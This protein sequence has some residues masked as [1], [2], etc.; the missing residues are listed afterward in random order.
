MAGESWNEAFERFG[1]WWRVADVDVHASGHLTFS[2]ENGLSLRTLGGAWLGGD[3]GDGRSVTHHGR[4]DD[5][6]WTLTGCWTRS[7]SSSGEV[8][9]VECAFAGVGMNDEELGQLDEIHVEFDG[10]GGQTDLPA[11]GHLDV[12]LD[13]HL[14]AERGRLWTPPGRPDRHLGDTRL[15]PRSLAFWVLLRDIASDV[16]VLRRSMSARKFDGG[17]GRVVDRGDLCVTMSAG[18]RDCCRG[19]T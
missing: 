1:T 6:L 5:E 18:A 4:V 17:I 9:H 10:V 8:F 19:W 2:P 16:S 12:P 3:L 15:M 7:R 13:G 14:N 11:G